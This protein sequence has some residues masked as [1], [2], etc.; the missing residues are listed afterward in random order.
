MKRNIL[1]VGSNSYV[2]KHTALLLK[3][4]GFNCIL[5]SRNNINPELI[6]DIEDE[7]GIKKFVEL[8]KTL[9]IDGIL[10]FQGLNPSRNTKEISSGDFLRMLTVNLVGPALLLK[11]FYRN[12][13]PNAMVLFMSSIA[14]TKGSYDP[15][16][17]SSKAALPGLMYSLANEF[18][19]IRFNCLSLGLIENSPVY[20]GM[21]E[22]FRAR[23]ADKMYNNEFIKVGDVASVI[24]ELLENKA[25]NRSII[26]INGGYSA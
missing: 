7:S 10:F 12:I 9:Q 3:E 26:P 25:I 15:S 16:Y 23:H 11:Y 8:N 6:L 24:A 20:N 2:A 19:D 21:T 17:A 18:K 14:A 13:N 1:F 22:D 5:S 4:R